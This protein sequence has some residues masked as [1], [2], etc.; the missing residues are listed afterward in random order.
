LD[1]LFKDLGLEWSDNDSDE[2]DGFISDEDQAEEYQKSTAKLQEQITKAENMGFTYRPIE[3][4]K[5]SLTLASIAAFADTT[6][7]MYAFNLP[8]Q[9]RCFLTDWADRSFQKTGRSS[10]L[11]TVMSF[12][13]PCK[14]VKLRHYRIL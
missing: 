1:I 10:S 2:D 9:Y 8:A 6:A 11:K 4:R 14:H 5:E 12:L 3:S 13:N 7:Q